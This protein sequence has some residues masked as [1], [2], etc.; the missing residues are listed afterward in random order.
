MWGNRPC[1]YQKSTGGQTDSFPWGCIG[2]PP[3]C[4]LS[5]AR[6]TARLRR[7]GPYGNRKN[8]GAAMIRSAE[9]IADEESD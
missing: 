4:G 1:D 5:G 2:S 3:T 9:G 7:C 8:S 6:N